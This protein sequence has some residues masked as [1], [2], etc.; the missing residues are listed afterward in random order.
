M[1]NV[2]HFDRRIILLL[3]LVCM[4]VGCGPA[5][6]FDYDPATDFSQYK[7]YNWFPTLETGVN[8]FDN[9]RMI[10]SVDSILQSRGFVESES[11]D[12]MINFYAVEE[13]VPPNTVGIGIGSGGGG[14]AVGGSGSIPVGGNKI[15]QTLT[16]D[17]VDP[18]KDELIWQGVAV[19]KYFTT[20]T[21]EQKKEHYLK[22]AF[23]LLQSYPP[24]K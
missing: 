21:A 2:E 3:F 17:F 5:A 22:V 12:F 1:E 20:A 8:E 11:A 24:R 9:R 6:K 10:R 15:L 23:K 13:I 19:R 7:T 16:L 18:A 14:I 4:V